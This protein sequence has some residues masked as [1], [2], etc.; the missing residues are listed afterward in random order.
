MR[1]LRNEKQLQIY[2]SRQKQQLMNIGYYHGYKGYRYAHQAGK[3]L[4]YRDFSELMAL[5][6]F[7]A[8]LKMLLY[9]CLM[10]LETVLKNAVLDI[11]L[12]YAKSERFT[13]VYDRVLDHYKQYAVED[14][15]GLSKTKCQAA[16]NEYRAAILYRLR[17]RNQLNT[18]VTNAFAGGNRIAV[19][20]LSCGQEL[21][22]WAMFELISLGEL[23]HFVGCMNRMCRR[24]LTEYLG[25]HPPQDP[26]ALMPQQILGVLV[27]IRNA[28][29]HN[30]PI[31]DGR[32]RTKKVPE[33]VGT[34]L[35]RI[36]GTKKLTFESALDDFLLIVYLETVIHTPKPECNAL[37][38]SYEAA[39]EKLR[40]NVPAAVFRQAVPENY[41]K[42][43]TVIKRYVQSCG[44][45][46]AKT[47][48][49]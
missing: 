25:F 4:P 48:K 9:P 10:E 18:V 26:Q 24:T 47:G 31:F 33:S 30:V 49:R 1:R 15:S 13:D 45:M 14:I 3:R 29:V 20:Y 21:P 38:A 5:Y 44:Q 6:E 28:L 19:H 46:R 32:F 2:G 23:R 8:S 36:L 41:P 34:A 40:E 37:I 35:G 16:E 17:L 11:S 42:K 27:G 7:D 22:L 39:V 12:H 43:I